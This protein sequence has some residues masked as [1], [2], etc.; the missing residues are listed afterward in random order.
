[1]FVAVAEFIGSDEGELTL[2]PGYR[3]QRIE[4]GDE[5]EWWIGIVVEPASAGR[6]M[7]LFR[8]HAVARP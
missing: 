3:V 1:M 5:D 6:P 8:R 4:G 2:R 7:G